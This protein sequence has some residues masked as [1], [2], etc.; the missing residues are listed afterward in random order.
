MCR[1]VADTTL[2]HLSDTANW[3]VAV[4]PAAGEVATGIS[5]LVS[6]L[7]AVPLKF[8]VVSTS[9]TPLPP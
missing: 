5:V 8:G 2:F 6:V 1:K 9:V 4:A 7:F 3:N